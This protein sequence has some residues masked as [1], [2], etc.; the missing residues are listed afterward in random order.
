MNDALTT[1]VVGRTKSVVQGVGGLFAFRVRTGV[2]NI[3]GLVL[4]S[5]GILWYAHEKYVDER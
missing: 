2:V 3:S 4:N 5:I 1:S